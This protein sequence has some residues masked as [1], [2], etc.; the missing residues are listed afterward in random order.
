VIAGTILERTVCALGIAGLLM[1]SL[2]AGE[3]P[4][5]SSL[6]EASVVLESPQDGHGE[7]LMLGNGDLY[8]VV[9]ERDG[10]LTMRVTKNDI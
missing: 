8:G 7:G 6:K 3:I 9:W 2:T 1:P 5:E 10:V 4:F